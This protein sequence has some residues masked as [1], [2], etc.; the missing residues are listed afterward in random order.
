MKDRISKPTRKKRKEF[1]TSWNAL[2]H[3]Y[4]LVSNES[5]LSQM[6][7]TVSSRLIIKDHISDD[8][9]ELPSDPHDDHRSAI[10]TGTTASKPNSTAANPESNV[11]TPRLSS[12]IL[13]CGSAPAT[14][15]PPPSEGSRGFNFNAPVANKFPSK[16]LLGLNFP[17]R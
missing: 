15:A 17:Q 4:A 5:D 12:P 10:S 6:L 16:P 1:I 14:L 7:E 9:R 2:G 3:V 8:H 11:G 13:F